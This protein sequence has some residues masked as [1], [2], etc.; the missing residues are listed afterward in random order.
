MPRAKRSIAPLVRDS[1]PNLIV[2]QV[3]KAI[4]VGELKPGDALPSENEL[5]Q[6]FQVGRTSVRE[7]LA[8]LEYMQVIRT[9]GGVTYVNG[10]VSAFFSRKILYHHQLDARRQAA[11]LE[12]LELLCPA[13]ATYAAQRA[14]V[15]DKKHLRRLLQGME[16]L[17]TKLEGPQ[18]EIL[19]E[20]L[21]RTHIQFLQALAEAAQNSIYGAIYQRLA[22]M[23]FSALWEVQDQAF[24]RQ[25]YTTCQSLL[26]AV[27]AGEGTGAGEAMEHYARSVAQR[28][29]QLQP[30]EGEEADHV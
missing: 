28:Y 9:E 18:S 25:L 13:F 8:G 14:S 7:A 26:Q 24:Y 17:L 5:I 4:Q 11:L 30:G 23:L 15:N 6:Q 22:P 21:V 2:N 20:E 27:E 3:L 16:E 1:Y 19:A 10:N 12:T 29:R